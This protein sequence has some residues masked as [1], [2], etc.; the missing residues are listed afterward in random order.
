MKTTFRHQSRIYALQALYSLLLSGNNINEIEKNFLENNDFSK[1]DEKY[2]KDLF[3]GI[4][5]SMDELDKY[6]LPH[7][8]RELKELTPIELCTLRIAVFELANKKDVPFR[9]IINE[10][11][12]LNKN[13]GSTD[14]FKY[15]NGILD[16]VAGD[17]RKSEVQKSS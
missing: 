14:G 15:V 13:F 11:I 4:T 3:R 10:A 5:S 16:K 7:L 8:D 9:V 6:M 2:F 1:T 12:E 17:L